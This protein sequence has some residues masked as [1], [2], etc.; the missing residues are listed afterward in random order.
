MVAPAGARPVWNWSPRGATGGAGIFRSARSAEQLAAAVD[1]T[2]KTYQPPVDLSSGPHQPWVQERNAYGTWTVPAS[3]SI[4]VV[5]RCGDVAG[6]GDVDSAD[7]AAVL[8]Q[9]GRVGAAI[10]VA[11]TD[12]NGDGR[13][14]AGT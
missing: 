2:A 14:D 4:E 11:G 10:A 1:T 13:V 3:A 8:G 9:F 5:D 7:R 6:D 12:S